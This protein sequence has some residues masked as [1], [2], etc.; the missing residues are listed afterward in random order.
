MTIVRQL[1][2]TTV[3]LTQASSVIPV[4]RSS[5]FESGTLTEAFVPLKDKAFPNLPAAAPA[6]VAFVS[7]PLLLLPDWSTAL[8]P[9]PVSKPYA[10]TSPTFTEVTVTDASFE[11]GPTLPPVSSA[12][13]L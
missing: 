1:F 7:V 2:A 8:V 10:A 12:V 11:A 3:G 9:L 13:T 6:Q 5:E 4:V